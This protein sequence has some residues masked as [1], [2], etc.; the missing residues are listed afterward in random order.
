MKLFTKLSLVLSLLVFVGNTSF[1]LVGNPA[2]KQIAGELAYTTNVPEFATMNLEQFLEI[3]PN[4]IKEITGHKLSLKETVKLKLAQKKV[5]KIVGKK[6]P[7]I[8]SSVY[9]LLVILGLGWVAMGLNDD[10]SGSDWIV[11]LLLTALCWLPGVIHGLSKRSK[12][13]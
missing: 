11:N 2:T 3:T 13:Y 5:A 9:V 8:E 10:W 12:W 1:A 4:Q 7:A 6:A